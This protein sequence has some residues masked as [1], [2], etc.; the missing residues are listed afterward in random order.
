M[1]CPKCGNDLF[2]GQFRCEKCGANIA[3]AL[4]QKE[5]KKQA[6]AKAKETKEKKANG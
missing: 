3:V 2:K 5:A 1:K 6:Q 4:A